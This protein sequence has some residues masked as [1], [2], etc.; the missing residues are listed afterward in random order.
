MAYVLDMISTWL[1]VV[2]VV[3]LSSSLL[4]LG[5]KL[6]DWIWFRPKKLEKLLRQQGFTGNSY[7]ILHGDLKER[8][9]MR[10]QAISKPMN[11]S[12]YIAP[13][14]IPSVHHTIQ[15]YGNTLSQSLSFYCFVLL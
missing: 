4:L 7:R 5:W 2:I 3:L 1:I 10:D 9:A 14:V 6:V 13:R 15:H 12:N 11:F 8:A